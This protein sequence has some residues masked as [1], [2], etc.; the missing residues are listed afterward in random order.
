[1]SSYQL[2]EVSEGESADTCGGKF[3]L[4]PMGGGAEGREYADLG[5]GTPIGVSGNL[6]VLFFQKGLS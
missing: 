5:A 6:G 2:V 4:T 1:M 3:P